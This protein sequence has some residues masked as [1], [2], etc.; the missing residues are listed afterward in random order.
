MSFAG[1]VSIAAFVGIVLIVLGSSDAGALGARERSVRE[2][3]RFDS[4]SFTMDGELI[5]TQGDRESLEIVATAGDLPNIVTEVRGS[6][7]FIGRQG[8]GPLFWSP[9]PVFKLTV[10]TITGLAV[11]SSGKISA[12]NLR[13]DSF[14]IEIGSSRGV[15]IDSLTADLLEVRL[16]SSGSLRLGGKVNEQNVLLSSS[17][18]YS[19]GALACRIAR[20]TASSS[21]SATLRASDSLEALVTSSGDVRYYGSPARVKGNVTSSGRLVRLGD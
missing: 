1:K 18:N 6:T 9:S 12:N 17:G 15:S 20:V 19:G 8:R 2:V 13:S 5:I 4:V 10:A 3:G 11:H 7:L 21:G 14:R 16:H